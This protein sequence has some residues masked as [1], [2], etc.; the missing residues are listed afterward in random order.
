MPRHDDM[1]KEARFTRRAVSRDACA[2]RAELP[3]TR[4]APAWRKLAASGRGRAD[5]TRDMSAAVGDEDGV[6]LR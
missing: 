3:G 5:K 1:G 2:V 4:A 6:S